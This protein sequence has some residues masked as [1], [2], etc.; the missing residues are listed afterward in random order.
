MSWTDTNGTLVHSGTDRTVYRAPNAQPSSNT[1]R[2]NIRG[3]ADGVFVVL[4]S[5]FDMGTCLEI[6]V[7]GANIVSRQVAFGVAGADDTTAHTISAGEPFFLDIRIEDGLIHAEVSA[8]GFASQAITPIPIPT[9]LAGFSAWGVSSEVDGATVI[10][11]EISE[12]TPVFTSANEVLVAA[13]AG[14]IWGS[15]SGTAFSRM[16]VAAFSS[17]TQPSFADYKGLLIG[18]DGGKVIA[19]DVVARTVWPLGARTTDADPASATNNEDWDDDVTG[20]FP[21]SVDNG[22]GT[23]KKG[24]TDAV[25]CCVFNER[26]YVAR[27]R[28]LHAS[29]IGDPQDWLYGNNQQIS[30]DGGAFIDTNFRDPIISLHVTPENTMIVGCE[31]SIRVIAGDPLDLS[32]TNLPSSIS[33]GTSGLNAAS[34]GVGAPMVVH[35]PAGLQLVSLSGPTGTPIP[36]S[37]PVLTDEIQFSDTDRGLYF[38]TLVRDPKAFGLHLFIT[39]K[40][41]S[42]HRGFWYDERV[43]GYQPGMGGFFPDLLPSGMQPTCAVNW[44]GKTVFGCLDGF[45]R[46]FDTAKTADDGVSIDDRVTSEAINI[47]GIDSDSVVHSIEL[48]GS[49]NAPIVRFFGAPTAE[50]AYSLLERE[51]KFNEYVEFATRRI[52]GQRAAVMV[53]EVRSGGMGRRYALEG[54]ALEATE[55]GRLRRSDFVAPATP[56]PGCGVVIPTAIAEPEIPDPEPPDTG[57]DDEIDPECSGDDCEHSEVTLDWLAV[58]AAVQGRSVPTLECCCSTEGPTVAVSMSRTMSHAA[59]S[60]TE[61]AEGFGELGAL[62]QCEATNTVG[63]VSTSG[64]TVDLTV[65]CGM[66]VDWVDNEDKKGFVDFVFAAGGGIDT[67]FENVVVTDITQPVMSVTCD[68]LEVG[69]IVDFTIDGVA[70]KAFNSLVITVLDR[71]IGCDA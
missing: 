56:A 10:A 39:P 33:T 14:D 21:G 45:L 17:E 2:A 44:R 69:M 5:S 48:E 28:E 65:N 29:A 15:T 38:T 26:L 19:C 50:K 25:A 41:G 61:S 9:D 7:E 24:T 71:T 63:G 42:V 4:F 43:G 13:C 35:T 31:R 53:C 70:G 34:V 12:R 27:G 11:L 22:G 57:G 68:R 52:V 51:L 37:A 32:Y 20:Y 54:A 8:S 47:G 58:A 23:H 67:T 55:A 1:I 49:G 16:G 59:L 40:D 36:L 64:Y 62:I 66:D 60:F 30:E 3:R 18:L 6:G 46:H